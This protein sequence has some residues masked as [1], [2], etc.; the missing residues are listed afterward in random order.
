MIIEKWKTK[1]GNKNHKNIASKMK[2]SYDPIVNVEDNFLI[3]E[4]VYNTVVRQEVKVALLDEE[5][6]ARRGDGS[7]QTDTM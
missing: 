2:T 7:H 5:K 1:K 4:Y 3:L 6:L